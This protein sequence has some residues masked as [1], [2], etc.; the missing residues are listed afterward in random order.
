MSENEF[1]RGAT[2]S[3][4]TELYEAGLMKPGSLIMMSG[5]MLPCKVVEL[6]LSKPGKTGWPKAYI[7]ARDIFT[8][9]NYEEIVRRNIDK[10]SQPLITT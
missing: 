3:T 6:T 9:K 1:E 5:G 7:K 8:N 10:I 2:G 4:F